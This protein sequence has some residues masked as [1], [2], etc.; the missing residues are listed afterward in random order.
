ML[1]GGF[2]RRMLNKR[3]TTA[4]ASANAAMAVK[5]PRRFQTAHI[6]NSAIQIVA[7]AANHAVTGWLRRTLK[8]HPIMMIATANVTRPSQR[9]WSSIVMAT[10]PQDRNGRETSSRLS[11]FLYCERSN[12][13]SYPVLGRSFLHG[14]D[15]HLLQEIEI[16]L[17]MPIVGD[18][19]V[20]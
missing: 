11:A 6:N 16:V 9:A 4:V 17:Y 10:V 19:T 5:E 15:T 7:D 14:G 12:S 13:R 1:A 2:R 8:P 18:A 3:E 20:P